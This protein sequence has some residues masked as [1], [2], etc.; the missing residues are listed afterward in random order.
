MRTSEISQ[1]IKSTAF[2]FVVVVVV[3]M[4]DDDVF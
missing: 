1:T 2:H 4:D 3:V